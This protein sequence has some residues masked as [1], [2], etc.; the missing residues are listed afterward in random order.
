VAIVGGALDGSDPK[1]DDFDRVV[2]K[3]RLQEGKKAMSLLPEEAV[4]LLLHQAQFHVASKNKTNLD[5][6]E[7][8]DYPCAVAI[9]AWASH[10]ASIEALHDATSH[11]GVFFQR[12]VC[13]L[14]GS[15]LQ[16]PDGSSNP[17]LER[18]EK[19]REALGKDFRRR[20]AED[21]GAS[22]ND[23]VLLVL[24]GMTHDGFEATAIQV[25]H[26]QPA[27][28]TCLF[29]NF[30]VLANVSYQDNDPLSRM[31]QSLKELENAIDLTAPEA[32]GPAGILTYGTKDLQEKMKTKWERVKSEQVEWTNVPLFTTKSDVVTMGTAMLGAVTHGRQSVLVD[33]G[34]KTKADLGLRVQNVS[35]CA[36]GVRINYHGGDPK[37]WEP[38]KV[39]F[40]FDRRIPAGPY[41][42]ELVASE[43]VVH[44]NGPKGL[45]DEDFLKAAKENEAAA[46]IPKREEA[47]LELRVEVLQKWTRDG[48]WKRVGDTMEPLVK[49]QGDADD[50]KRIACERV[51]LEISLGVTGML[52]SN[53]VGDR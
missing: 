36:V 28:R 9:P 32:D 35:P 26:I 24:L 8:V 52:T 25:S 45:S 2:Y 15:L 17:V 5:D 44:R 11:T 34:G 18:L 40:D 19:V 20:K 49:L 3:V 31:A 47:A 16:T 14:A 43:C 51:A 10:D 6:E 1:G 42:V 41:A 53:M 27:L 48:Q 39:I 29:G 22:F 21:P 4:Q 46:C 38:I 23:D 30:K 33:K 12:S 50:E 13:A 7:I 37:Q